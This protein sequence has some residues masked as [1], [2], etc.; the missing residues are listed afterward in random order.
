MAKFLGLDFLFMR[1]EF[2][3]SI[4]T[5]SSNCKVLVN[6]G[7]TGEILAIKPVPEHLAEKPWFKQR[8]RRPRDYLGIPK[9]DERVAK[10]SSMLHYVTQYGIADRAV[11]KSLHRISIVWWKTRFEDMRK[12]ANSIIARIIGK[13]DQTRNPSVRPKGR[14]PQIPCLTGVK[15]HSNGISAPLWSYVQR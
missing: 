15:N 14:L 3:Q 4:Q 13:V 11:L 5:D 8:M 6:S 7:K 10:L 1:R 2:C 12:H 9:I